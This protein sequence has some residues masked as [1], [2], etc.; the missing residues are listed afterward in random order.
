MALTGGLFDGVEDTPF[1][2]ARLRELEQDADVLRDRSSRLTR[3][4]RAYRDALE[5]A[6]ASEVNFQ[7]S[8][9]S[10]YG[11]IDD[12]FGNA[13]GASVLERLLSAMSE[14]AAAR[15]D[16]MSE[17]ETELIDP[18]AKI[19]DGP[20]C[21]EVA[22]ARRRFDRTNADH[23]RAR[24]KF[25]ALTKDAKEEHLRAAEDELASTRHE[26]ETARFDLMGKLQ[27]AD[28]VRRVVFKR[29]LARNVE[30]HRAFF[31]RVHG[32][33]EELGAFVREVEV[34]CDDDEERAAR[35]AIDL[36]AAAAAYRDALREDA[37]AAAPPTHRRGSSVGSG[38]PG[39]HRRG[40]SF[41]G[42]GGAILHQGYLLK[43]SSNLRADW[44]RR[45]FVLDALGHLTYYRDKDVS[46]FGGAKETVRLLTATIKPD[47]EDSPNMR[48]CF[49]VVSPEREYCLQAENQAD[50]AR[51]MEAISTAIAGLLS[52]SHVIAESVAEYPRSANASPAKPPRPNRNAVTHRATT[53]G[54]HR[55]SFS[56]RQAP[57]NSRCADCGMADPDWASLNLGIVVCI[58]CSGVHR[59]LGVHVSKV[60]SCVLDVRAWEPS[61][62]AFFTRWGNER[63]NR[64]F[65]GAACDADDL[66]TKPRPNDGLD[67]K[68]AYIKAKYV[69]KAFFDPEVSDRGGVAYWDGELADAIAS[70]DV[71]RAMEAIARGARVNPVGV[72]VVGEGAHGEGAHS[73]PL[74][75]VTPPLAAAAFRGDE[76]MV[77][78]LVQ[79]GADVNHADAGTGDT[80]LHVAVGNDQ[81]GVAKLLIRRGARVG[82]RDAK[83][84]SSLERAMERGH[85]RDEE[86]F[87]MLAE[88]AKHPTSL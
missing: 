24:A 30:S 35:D 52:N 63:H 88:G 42:S 72:G 62:V 11:S 37:A 68:A 40:S 73:S 22:D 18:L 16:L 78:A 13:V 55:R 53:G 25:L 38:H 81:D 76:P 27:R 2:R 69:A 3:D 43:R 45:F 5:D 29:R 57:G 4:C 26:F 48:F 87:M 6:Y 46:G 14:C 19:A 71:A 12:A 15:C 28:A 86:L 8:V 9:R 50:R 51:W 79:N 61:V 65:E 17:V 41:G 64:V 10:L 84:R 60:R 77:E 20:V 32:A 44:K 82:E 56:I 7:E 67:A 33:Y 75:Y 34:R 66:A 85:I 39:H 83:G 80:P 74:S 70:R 59:Q 21:Q 49:R 1:L 23:E 54:T 58:Q 47:L 31:A 36:G